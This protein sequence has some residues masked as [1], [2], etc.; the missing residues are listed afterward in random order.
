MKRF[1][2]QVALICLLRVI[3]W[4]TDGFCDAV[5]VAK[6]MTAS[7]IAEIF[8]EEDGIRLEMEIGP[9]DFEAFV[10][11][12][13]DEALKHLGREPRPHAERIKAFLEHDFVIRPEKGEPLPGRL[14]RM[15]LQKR[16]SRDEITGEPLPVQPEHAESV[17][18]VELAYAWA[19]RPDSLVVHPPR[20]E[21]G[22]MPSASIGFVLY[23]N[24]VPVNDFRYL[25]VESTVDLDWD[26][27]WFS[28]FRHRN[29][30]RQYD[31]PLSVF[32]YVEHFEV[33][34]E[35][36]VR[37]KDLQQWVDLGLA[38]KETIPAEAQETLKQQV[39]GFL[40]ERSPVKVD[41][42]NVEGKLDR[43]HFI[44][45]TLRTT[46]VVNPPEE[47]DLNTATLGVI[48]VYPIDGL[49]Q[50]ASLTWDLFA[51]RI[52]KVPAAATDEAGAMPLTLTSDNSEL[53]W[54]N[55]LSNPTMPMMMAVL[56][57]ETPRISVPVI[58]GIC[59]GLVL[60]LVPVGLRTAKGKEGIP[61]GVVLTGAVALVLGVLSLPYAR[62][63][64][65]SPLAQ[66]P[67]LES[68]QAEEVFHALLYNVYRAFDRRDES[69][70]YDRLALSIS[71]DLL[72]DVYLQVR[73]SMELENQGGAR[74]KVDEVTIVDVAEERKSDGAAFGY[75]CRWTAAGSVGHWGHIHRR[76]N[77]YDAVIT[78]EPVNEV[79][80]ITTIDLREERRIDTTASK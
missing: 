29:L 58:S 52:P 28:R 7:T 38:G 1:P 26:D 23:H 2:S 20:G 60:L 8:V 13:P 70:V 68:E 43:I 24:G 25:P 47:L 37:P 33:R 39:A 31:A 78:I 46:G 41:G 21:G 44:R 32:L 17:L 10:D 69:L 49:P 65:P 5:V 34:K 71:G 22:Q 4:P 51:P 54:Q 19:N 15:A 72:T 79:W 57:P 62:A 42:R 30:R 75:R 27:P 63:S 6:A 76:A 74:V 56:P 48:F 12:V 18:F 55:F 35:I 3:V 59:F 53:R 11:L 73:R 67:A 16:L 61:R 80:K 50:E 40:A 36:I 9:R 66:G 77:Q 64:L 45:R 14:V